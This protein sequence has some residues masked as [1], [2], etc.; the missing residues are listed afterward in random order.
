MFAIRIIRAL[1]LG[2]KNW[3][4]LKA[5]MDQRI[6]TLEP[7]TESIPSM[8]IIVMVGLYEKFVKGNKAWTREVDGGGSSGHVL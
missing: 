2:F 7:F 3:R 8:Y 1:L 4:E 5:T 6:G